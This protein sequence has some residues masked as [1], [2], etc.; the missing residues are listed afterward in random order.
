MAKNQDI[1]IES[2]LP[3]VQINGL[4]TNKNAYIGGNLQV[5]GTLTQVSGDF[6]GNVTVGGTVTATGA[7][8][9]VSTVTAV[10]ATVPVA[11]GLPAT[12]AYGFSNIANFGVYYG[13]GAPG[14]ATGMA[15]AT[16]S[17]ALNYAGSGTGNRA[18][19]CAGGT[20]WIAIITSS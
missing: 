7:I 13:T 10:N 8:S 12:Q 6:S 16:G 2:S 3:I 11:A 4:N 20:A 19:L 18:Y 5:D 17:I 15:A 14:G 9:T 1:T